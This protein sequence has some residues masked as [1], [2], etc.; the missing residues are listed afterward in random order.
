MYILS[1]FIYEDVVD[2]VKKL[3]KYV[4]LGDNIRYKGTFFRNPKYPSDVDIGCY[5]IFKNKK[6]SYEMIKNVIL[7]LPKNIIYITLDSGIDTSIDLDIKLDDNGY[8]VDYNYEKLKKKMDE[9][10]YK[11]FITQKDYNNL[12]KFLIKDQ[13]KAY[14]A[15][16]YKYYKK[17]IMLKWSYNE[18]K[19]GS[20]KLKDGTIIKF[21]DTVNE[22]SRV[23]LTTAFLLKNDN[24]IGVDTNYIYDKISETEEYK[25][26]D[27]YQIFF[28]IVSKNNFKAIKRLNTYLRLRRRHISDKNLL[29]KINKI[30]YSIDQ[31]SYGV[32]GKYYHIY[33]YIELL[34]EI[35]DK[36]DKKQ[37]N[38]QYKKIEDDLKNIGI[39]MLIKNE[40]DLT[41]TFD[42]VKIKLNKKSKY[43]FKKYYIEIIQLFGIKKNINF[44]IFDELK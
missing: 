36:L 12:N 23:L 40:N 2:E 43:Y 27:I 7:N 1:M 41:K 19:N 24:I 14:S 26:V 17:I 9:L 29:H 34:L 37:I 16:L 20:K 44:D 22:D 33:T 10:L 8:I 18:I 6:E 13:T 39:P 25:D 3:L 28:S 35:H 31:L 15:I 5:L 38:I 4:E 32:L 42:K 21:E 30:I 11:K